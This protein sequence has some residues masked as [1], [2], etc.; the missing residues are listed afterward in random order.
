MKINVF[1]TQCKIGSSVKYK[2]K[3]R[4]VVDINR[5][6]NEVCLDRRLWVRCTEVELLTSEYDHAKRLEIRRNKASRKG[7]RQE[8]GNTL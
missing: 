5:S 8:L 7:T 1:K 4:K 6:T 2:Q 3:T